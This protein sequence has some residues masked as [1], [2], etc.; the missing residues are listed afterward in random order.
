MEMQ[1]IQKTQTI[2][3]KNQVGRLTLPDFK[4]DYIGTAIKTVWHWHNDG[5]INQWTGTKESK[6]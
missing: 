3:K 1:G 6:N 2:L 5:H 4:T